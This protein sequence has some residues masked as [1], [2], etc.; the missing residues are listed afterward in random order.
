MRD[1]DPLVSCVMPT[2]DRAEYARQAVRY[3]LRQDYPEKELII[4]DDG[5]QPLEGF[6]SDSRIRHIRLP[7]RV[8]IGAKRNLGCELARGEFVAQWD[9]D[10][11][12]GPR[13]LSEQIAPLANG[14]ADITGMITG[15]IVELNRWAFWC[16]TPEIHR[17]MFA[18]DVHG[19]TLAYRRKLW[20]D[21]TRYPNISLG[22]D[23][24]FLIAC[25]NAKARLT[26]V[27]GLGHFIYV[28]HGMNS[29][30]FSCGLHID[31]KGW[32]PS[33]EPVELKEDRDFY[34]GRGFPVPSQ[35]DCDNPSSTRRGLPLVSCVMIASGNHL[36]DETAIDCFLNQSYP[37]RELLVLTG[38]SEGCKAS[39]RGESPIRYLRAPE[40][41][42]LGAKLNSACELAGGEIILHWHPSCVMSGKTIAAA[43]DALL[44]MGADI[45]GT[46]SLYYYDSSNQESWEYKYPAG[47][48]PMLAR[49]TLGYTRP[50]WQKHPFEDSDDAP[51]SF[52][53][54]GNFKIIAPI[55]DTR[56]IVSLAPPGCS[57][58]RAGELDRRPVSREFLQARI[59]KL[60][61]S[62]FP[63]R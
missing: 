38:E 28:R 39:Q 54:A 53:V 41:G 17:L 21:G 10:D 29:W 9:D 45:C 50:Y 58:S 48:R 11:W 6:E 4:V 14:G 16:I 46:Q 12:Y 37:N 34:S 5:V 57:E 8:S 32:I 43:V 24:M 18:W 49:E 15:H 44:S 40:G 19:S 47:F 23:A 35:A 3:F 1:R 20:S 36:F 26:R 56:G 22:E 55:P 25:V 60:S 33:A 42:S 52:V 13:R 62:I 59:K 51:E 7:S 2:R 31:P 63:S 61:L 30:S 27:E